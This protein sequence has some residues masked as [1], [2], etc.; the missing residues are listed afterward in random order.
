MDLLQAVILG[1]V[2]GLTEFIPV[3]SS[4]HM[5][6][7]SRLTNM[8]DGNAEA[9]TATMAVVQLGTLAAVFIYFAADIL[10]ISI[11]FFLDHFPLFTGRRGM[12]FSSPH[13]I[14]PLLL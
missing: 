5:V 9:I 7:V 10:S 8:Y 12:R 14:L 11:A 2:Q 4:A 3:S 13:P 6:F 1:I